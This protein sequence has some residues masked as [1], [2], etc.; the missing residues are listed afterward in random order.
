MIDAGEYS[1]AVV[2]NLALYLDNAMFFKLVQDTGEEMDDQTKEKFTKG[3]RRAAVAKKIHFQGRLYSLLY[4]LASGLFDKMQ[5]IPELFPGLPTSKNNKTKTIHAIGK[6]IATKRYSHSRS[7][8][9][10]LLPG[11]VD[12]NLANADEYSAQE[13]LFIL[14]QKEVMYACHLHYGKI[15]E[16]KKITLDDKV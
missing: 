15:P 7:D 3:T 2:G 6:N 4:Q 1:R 10:S 9:H 16:S 5:G 8:I 13:E 11:K 14:S 12:L